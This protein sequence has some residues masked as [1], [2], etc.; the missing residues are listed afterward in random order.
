MSK[1]FLIIGKSCSRRQEEVSMVRR[2]LLSNDWNETGRLQR[3]D[4]IVFFACAGVRCIVNENLEEIAETQK[5]MKPGAELIVGSCLPRMDTESL[6]SVFKGR[7]I[8][9]T[10]FTALNDLPNV[11]LPFEA[12]PA[13][14]GRDAACIQL[15]HP[16]SIAASRMWI[17]DAA[18]QCVKFIIEKRPA[19]FLKRT[20]FWLKR[21]N[22]V[23]FSVAAGCSRK[24]A[25]CARPFAS[26]KVRSKPIEVVVENIRRGLS[27][28]Y[29]SYNLYAD[30]IG[31]YGSDLDVSLGDLLERILGIDG[32]FTIGLYDVHA[33]DF[34]RF[35]HPI[36]RLCESGKLHYLYVG[37][38]SGNERIL[39]LMRRPCDVED[40]AAKLADIRRFEHVFMQSAIIAGFPGETDDEF[41]DTLRLLK[42]VNFDNV[43]VHCYCDMPNT[44]A[45]GMPAKVD[46]DAVRGRLTRVTRAG[47]HHDAAEALQEWDGN[48]AIHDYF[49]HQ[50]R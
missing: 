47:I 25:Y 17:E 42:R 26:G 48:P 37:V 16:G 33:Q 12:M 11:R 18:F 44:E 19:P 23:S 27:L 21:R 22:I 8:T 9:P 14:W 24:C 10:D 29:R 49:G 28:G 2:F 3:A 46:K 34:I 36:K 50:A 43:F 35:V 38:Q 20:A 32:R 5:R 40:L 4:L 6:R 39:K 15:K 41:E 7:T 13:M 45:S 30:S 31:T 1:K